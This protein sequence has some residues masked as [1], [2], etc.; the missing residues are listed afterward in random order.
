MRASKTILSILHRGFDKVK[1]GARVMVLDEK[2]AEKLYNRLCL[3]RSDYGTY[4]IVFENESGVFK[5]ILSPS[6]R[7]LVPDAYLRIF[8]KKFMKDMSFDVNKPKIGTKSKI[9]KKRMEQI[10]QY[11]DEIDDN[12]KQ[13]ARELNDLP[14]SEDNR[15]NIAVCFKISSIKMK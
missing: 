4:K 11:V 12:T 6:N 5:D 2:S 15:D 3:E 13:L 7:W 14:T 9:P 10:E 8:G 1:Q